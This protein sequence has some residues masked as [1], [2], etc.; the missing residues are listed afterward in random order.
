MCVGVSFT[1]TFPQNNDS[2]NECK[3]MFV[4]VS[5][6]AGNIL[7]T[8]ISCQKCCRC[9]WN[10]F[11]CFDSEPTKPKRFY[12]YAHIILAILS[13]LQRRWCR[14]RIFITKPKVGITVYPPA[15]HLSRPNFHHSPQVRSRLQKAGKFYG[16]QGVL[17]KHRSHLIGNHFMSKIN[18]LQAN[19]SI[20][21]HRGDR[22]NL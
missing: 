5:H 7:V 6:V 16:W 14:R 3:C 21:S 1:Y 8:V 19:W 10:A 17:G 18:T 2:G 13:G 12:S 11:E 20:E 15:F 4:C 22:G 9:H